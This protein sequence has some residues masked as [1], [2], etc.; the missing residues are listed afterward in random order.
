M[1][2]SSSYIPYL[3]YRNLAKFIEYRELVLTSGITNKRRADPSQ[4][5][6]D[7]KLK[8]Q[9]SKDQ[10]PKDQTPK[11]QLPG[12][13]SAKKAA[14]AS[15]AAQKADKDRK[16]E[17]ATFLTE[18]E[19]VQTIQVDGYV[20]LSAEDSPNKIRRFGRDI[21]KINRE[22]PTK[23]HIIIIKPDSSFSKT[24]SNFEKLMNR[25]PNLIST[26]RN[27]NIDI[28]VI[29]EQSVKSNILKKM[30]PFNTSGDNDV[31]FVR[32]ENYP[33]KLFT[34]VI[35]EHEMVPKHRILNEKEEREVLDQLF[36]EKKSLPK[37]KKSDPPVV[38]VGGEVGDIIEILIPSEAVGREK[39][40]RVVIPL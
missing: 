29:T 5:L 23:T 28:L 14:E 22:R 38:W 3:V 4:K 40:Y 10:K 18:N 34:S 21:S 11:K 31:G 20:I 6:K 24:S 32:I 16:A 8:D 15:E 39:K 7:Q 27:H 36:I 12:D 2:E 9:K 26:K 19:L 35:P 25:V 37:I 33:Y 17:N 13:A 1:Q 30:T